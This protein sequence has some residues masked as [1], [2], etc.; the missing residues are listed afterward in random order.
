MTSPARDWRSHALRTVRKALRQASDAAADASALRNTHALCNRVLARLCKAAEAQVADVVPFET[1]AAARLLSQLDSAN[2]AQRPAII[3]QLAA[4]IEPQATRCELR[5]A[6]AAKQLAQ[7][8]AVPIS[9][10]FVD[11]A[12]VPASQDVPDRSS[13]SD[14][15]AAAQIQ[16]Y[17]TQRFPGA[18]LRLR[19][20]VAVPGGRSKI[21]VMMTIEP[22][23]LL[24][25]ELVVR[26]D[27]AASAQGTRVGDEFSVLQ[28]LHGA[29]VRAPQPL[30]LEADREPLGAPFLVMRR[31]IG[32][33]PGDYWSAGRASP[34][35]CRDLAALLA[36]VHRPDAVIAWP[37]AA[38]AARDCV[39]E[40]LQVYRER[41]RSNTSDAAMTSG[42]EFT[43]G[44]GI[45]SGPGFALQFGYDWLERRVDCIDGSSTPVHG[46]V[47]FGNLLATGDN[48]DCLT[49]W[50]FAHAGHPA[51]DL[52]FC[53][54]QIESVLPWSEFL[55]CYR[56]AGGRA[57]NAAQLQFFE[58]W[59]SLR[60]LTLASI[61]MQT[62]SEGAPADLQTLVIA[63]DARP[64]LEAVLL[65]ALATA[66]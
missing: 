19:T 9:A 23:A 6:L 54:R 37:G 31:S 56:A 60:N 15:P 38:A 8:N 36:D 65:R 25:T 42:L 17:L 2:G 26:L 40:M 44:P 45:T 47:H 41:W 29:G 12:D 53:R 33:A 5:E 43:S 16:R 21:T 55:K 20:C 14:A 7:I 63:L 18:G 1:S 62:V 48:I 64:R 59:T 49:D 32:T 66:L 61:V 4:I 51:D 28:A 3:R 34:A 35:L 58:I 39:C 57:V 13:I 52:A 24:P 50:E 30:W 11:S 10:E 46:D 27:R 22:N